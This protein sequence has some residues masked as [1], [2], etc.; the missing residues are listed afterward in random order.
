MAVPN[1][2]DLINYLNNLKVRLNEAINAKINY[3]KLYLDSIKNSFVIKNP[4]IIFEA[5]K[6]KL[7]LFVERINKIMINNISNAKH[8]LDLLKNNH[9]MTNPSIL[10]RDKETY[11]NNLIEKIELLNPLNS[12]KRGFSITYK[13]DKLLNDVDEVKINDVIDIRLNNGFLK[14][15][16]SAKNKEDNHGKRE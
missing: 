9:I 3:Q 8:R 12:L 6:Q 5:K 10:Y 11:L 15:V 7:D 1:L 14:A 2:P 13:N 16:V 4:M